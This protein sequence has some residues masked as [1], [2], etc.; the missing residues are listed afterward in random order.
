MTDKSAI[1]ILVV[2]DEPFML[3]LHTH[4][5]A[6]LGYTAVTTCEG[7][8]RALEVIDNAAR[9]PDLILMDLNMPELDGVELV[10]YL[11]K[12][13][14]PGSL[15]LLSGED[16]RMLQAAEKLVQA[17]GITMLGYLHKPVKPALLAALLEKWTPAALV[18]HWTPLGTGEAAAVDKAYAAEEVRAAIA[19]GE[20]VNY[21]QP[22]VSLLTGHVVGAEALVRW[23]HPVDGLVFPDQ[24]IGVAE[25][26]GLIQA[27]TCTVITSALTQIR[28]WRQETGLALQVAI[29]VS[30][31]DLSDLD[32]ADYVAGEAALAGVPAKDVTLEVTESR[33]MQDIRAPLEVLT[34]LRLKRFRLSIDDF[35]AGH[36]SFAQLRDLPFDELKI[37]RGFVRGACTDKTV[38]AICDTS[39]MLAK[40]LNMSI[41]AEGVEDRADWEFV[42]RSG[43]NVAQGYF[44]ARPMPAADLH[45]WIAEWEERAVAVA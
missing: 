2:D 18:Q 38:R 45:E 13:G 23:R 43:C 35:G 22:K 25:A 6:N 32:F 33:L 3:K 30:M 21:Y 7:G 34:R 19:N 15:I 44:I 26:H 24:F 14:Y 10:R 9:P 16:E 20:L 4:T 37:D 42:R 5:L 28:D 31:N 17:H 11:G 27:L 29:N 8:V 36:S 40:Q 39:V 41:V 1:K 12:R